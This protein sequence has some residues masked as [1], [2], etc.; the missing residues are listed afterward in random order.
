MHLQQSRSCQNLVPNLSV[1]F[2]LQRLLVKRLAEL[3]AMKNSIL[4]KM[5]PPALSISFEVSDK[6]TLG[7]TSKTK[8]VSGWHWWAGFTFWA[9]GRYENTVQENTISQK[10]LAEGLRKL[11][12][13]QL[14]RSTKEWK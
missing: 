5:D 13:K 3:P 6:K 8:K 14:K 10:A 4:A 12:I 7:L 1:L 2:V 11:S 9:A